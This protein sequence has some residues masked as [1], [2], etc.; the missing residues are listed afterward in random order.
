MGCEAELVAALS[1]GSYKPSKPGQTDLVKG[2]W[3]KLAGMFCLCPSLFW[4][5]YPDCD[6]PGDQEMPHQKHT[7]SLVIGQTKIY[8]DVLLTPPL[9]FIGGQN[10][11]VPEFW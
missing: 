5:Q 9:N 4:Y 1:I 11:E 7:R 6:P 3:R 10:Q 8:S 2:T